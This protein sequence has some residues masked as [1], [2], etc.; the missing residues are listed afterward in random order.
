MFAAATS[1]VIVVDGE[2]QRF[3]L[4]NAVHRLL[5]ATGYPFA[6]MMLG[7]SV[8]DEH[9]PQFIGLYEGDRCRKYVRDRVEQADAILLAGPMLT[10]FNTGGFSARI[11]VGRS[12]AANVDRLRVRHHY[13]DRV[14][15]GDFLKG[16]ADRLPRRDAATLDLQHA[17]RACR[18]RATE[19]FQP[20][21]AAPLKLERFFHRISHFLDG[22]TTMIVETGSALFA[23][24]EVLM[25]SGCRFMSQTFFGS[26]GYT[27]GA[28]LGAALA[29][30]ER[31]TC[32]FVG[33]G[34]FQVTAQDLSTMIRYGANPIVFLL[35]NDGYLVERV[36]SDGP[37]NDLQPW[38]YARLPEVFGGG[39]GCKVHTEGDL[40]RALAEA[41]RR[42]NDVVFIEVVL[43]RWD[44]PEAMTQ[45]GKAMA[46][47]NYLLGN[48]RASEPAEAL[49]T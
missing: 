46:R 45:A 25:P 39:Y 23:G 14:A 21:D 10:D 35:N 41:K 22:Q 4:E 8:I 26:I 28:T 44:S 3:G 24:A 2:V 20:I 47:N 38:D 5:D 49:A 36:I 7:K 37:F 11:D 43:D 17:S 48:V 13:Y 9:H 29:A 32:L 19:N 27:V 15:V 34:S 31:R 16:L 42:P 33:D 30:P 1:P 40:E 6:A 12:I 18:H